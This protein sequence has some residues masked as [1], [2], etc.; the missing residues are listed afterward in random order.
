MVINLTKEL[1]QEIFEEFPVV[2]DAYVRYV[3]GVCCTEFGTRHTFPIAL[4]QS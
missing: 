2:Q 4:S 3:P 1:V